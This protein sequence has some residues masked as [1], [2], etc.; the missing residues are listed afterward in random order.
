MRARAPRPLVWWALCV[1]AGLAQAASLAWPWPPLD[2]LGLQT[3][4]PVGWLQ[5]LGMGALV[6]ALRSA[7]SARAA[8]GRAAFLV[9]HD[10]KAAIFQLQKA[11]CAS[12]QQNAK[13]LA[14][15]TDLIIDHA[16]TK[17]FK[18]IA[19]SMGRRSHIAK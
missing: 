3:G 4:Q 12:A 8:F 15:K 11:V 5:V 14:L 6:L 1:L 16:G 19:P 13:C 9:I 17:A 18:R 2:S 7:P 10:Q